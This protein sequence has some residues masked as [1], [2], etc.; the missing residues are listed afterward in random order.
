LDESANLHNPEKR[1]PRPQLASPKR[2][3][4]VRTTPGSEVG[5]FLLFNGTIRN[6]NQ[7]VDKKGI[8]FIDFQVY[9]FNKLL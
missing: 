9:Y 3:Q 5:I 7:F 8:V 6:K 1:S 4:N 2:R